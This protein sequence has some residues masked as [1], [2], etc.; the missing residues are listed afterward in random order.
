MLNVIRE[1]GTIT[2]IGILLKQPLILSLQNPWKTDLK[3]EKAGLYLFTLEVSFISTISKGLTQYLP[4]VSMLCNSEPGD[5][6][7]SLGWI[8]GSLAEPSKFIFYLTRLWWK[9]LCP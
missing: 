1:K 5:G 4:A 7:L 6:V 3:G 8:M 2:K 9:A